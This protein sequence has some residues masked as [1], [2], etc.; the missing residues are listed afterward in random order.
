GS[1]WGRRRVGGRVEM[2]LSARGKLFLS[3]EYAVL[4][5]GTARLAGVGPRAFAL[6]RT[7]EDKEVHL[8]LAEGR[9]RGTVTPLGV[10]WESEPGPAVAFAARALDVVVR[11]RARESLG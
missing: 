3:G 6:A 8:V 4:W 7:R 10:R 11:A 2:C 9:L 5:G 1:G